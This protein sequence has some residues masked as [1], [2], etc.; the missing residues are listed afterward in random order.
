M[1][2]YLEIL[3]STTSGST[4]D[5]KEP[6]Y[7]VSFKS[8][9][10]W[11]RIMSEG[12]NSPHFLSKVNALNSDCW[13]LFIFSWCCMTSEF[14]PCFAKPKTVCWKDASSAGQRCWWSPTDFA[15]LALKRR[16][17]PMQQPP[18]WSVNIIP[19]DLGINL[20]FWKLQRGAKNP[21]FCF[22]DGCWNWMK[23]DGFEKM[24]TIFSRT[25]DFYLDSIHLQF[26]ENVPKMD[27]LRKFEKQLIWPSGNGP[28]QMVH[29]I[30]PSP[31]FPWNSRSI[32]LQSPPFGEIGRV[33]SL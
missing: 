29:N 20:I 4:G 17:P 27:R 21:E 33:R 18:P 13:I 6:S 14:P 8:V 25:C 30:S 2:L 22:R 23:L 31:R 5:F 11:F 32:P 24:V 10:K 1:D 15:T 16:R 9:M 12:V 7:P 26:Q 19:T 3:S 28:G